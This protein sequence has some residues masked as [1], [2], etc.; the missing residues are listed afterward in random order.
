MCSPTNYDLKILTNIGYCIILEEQNH[1]KKKHFGN[2]LRGAGQQTM[3]K[4]NIQIIA[5]ELNKYWKNAKNHWK[6]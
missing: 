1:L 3:I 5:R 2:Y 6:I 4:K